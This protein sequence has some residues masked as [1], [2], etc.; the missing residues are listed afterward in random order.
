MADIELSFENFINEADPKYHDFVMKMHEY[1]IQNN[2]KLK[3]AIAKNGYVVSYQ[4]GKKKRVILNYVFRKTG[5]FARIYADNIGHYTE[6]LEILPEK[7]SKTVEKSPACKRFAD[8]P[9]CNPKCVGYVFEMNKIQHQKCR[10]NCFLLAVDD[11][12]IPVIKSLV[13]EE[14]KSRNKSEE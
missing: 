5:L 8:P 14:L 3:L 12:S 7:I 1:L 6:V 11:E 9:K 10:Y 4:Y 2:C 13:E